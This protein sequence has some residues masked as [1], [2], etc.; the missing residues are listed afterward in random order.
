DGGGYCRDKLIVLT[1]STDGSIEN[2]IKDASPEQ[3][4]K[5]FRFI[6]HE[7][8]HL[9]WLKAESTSWEDWLNESFAE[10]SSLMATRDFYGEK[11]FLRLINLYKEKTL[12]LP[13]VRGIDRSDQDAFNVLYA[14]GPTLLYQLE[15]MIGA[16]A[17]KE[18]LN[19]IHMK[20]INNTLDFLDELTLLTSK[21]TS[22]KFSKLLDL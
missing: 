9:W 2:N 14:K 21:D 20:K 4:I 3:Q 10:Y 16:V 15:I 11:E 22:K 5:T 8:A 12:N 1:T 13:A 6:A 19:N 18:L 7:L 17:F